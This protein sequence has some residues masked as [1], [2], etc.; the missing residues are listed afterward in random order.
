M[1]NT[2]DI[3]HWRGG[4]LAF[5]K[6]MPVK[7]SVPT[8]SKM[9][10]QKQSNIGV[11]IYVLEFPLTFFQHFFLVSPHGSNRNTPLQFFTLLNSVRNYKFCKFWHNVTYGLR[12]FDAAN[13][14]DTL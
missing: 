12:S 1:L 13:V 2:P 9:I 8:L 14:S 6:I 10:V 7:A 4:I 3:E 11:I 5:E